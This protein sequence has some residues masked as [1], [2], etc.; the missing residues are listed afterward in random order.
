MEHI[1]QR[2]IKKSVITAEEVRLW[3]QFPKAVRND[4]CF[5]KI[6]EEHDR[7]YGME[8]HFRREWMKQWWFRSGIENGNVTEHH[9]LLE[10]GSVELGHLGKETTARNDSQG[11]PPMGNPRW[12][13]YVK[14]VVLMAT[15]IFATFFML[16]VK[17]KQPLRQLISIENFQ[18]KCNSTKYW[19]RRRSQWKLL[20]DTSLPEILGS[21]AALTLTGPF[22]L[23]MKDNETAGGSLTVSLEA[24]N[25]GSNK[26][27]PQ[28]EIPIL[29]ANAFDNTS[30][31]TKHHTFHLNASSGTEFYLKFETNSLQSVPLQLVFDP[32]PVDLSIGPLY[33][34]LILIFLNVLIIS[35]VCDEW[36]IVKF[37]QW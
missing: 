33:A 18:P 23:G 5:A 28:W 26:I 19:R 27:I 24:V 22:K 37:Y 12:L 21:Q 13:N 4:Q 17:E 14:Y 16:T 6:R 11:S 31:A 1:E 15:W 25:P 35:E 20:S 29:E 32:S 34:G 2:S 7:L 36:A 3:K 8:W 10:D 9:K 30:F